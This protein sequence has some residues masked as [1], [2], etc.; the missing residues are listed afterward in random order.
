[1]NVFLH[2]I[3]RDNWRRAI[4]LEVRPDQLPDVATNVHSIA[5]AYT[6]PTLR[7]LLIYP[8]D[9]D[10]E[11]KDEPVG[12]VMYE[13]ADCGIGFILRLMVDR[14]HQGK[15]YGRAA[16]IETIRRLRHE[17]GVQRIATSHR[18]KNE[19]ASRLYHSLGFVEW[20]VSHWKTKAEG[21]VFLT[22]LE[23]N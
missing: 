4:Q 13:V 11:P 12:F 14:R 8:G 19:A 21:E 3:N 20:D 17:S 7:P 2:R 23:S 5:E 1:M 16:M 15:G 9:N 18:I 6:D 10:P 22:L